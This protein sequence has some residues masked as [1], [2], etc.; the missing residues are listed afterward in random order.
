MGAGRSALLAIS[1][2]HGDVLV[3]VGFLL[4]L[5]AGVRLVAA[6]VI[7]PVRRWRVFRRVVAGALL[8]VAGGLL[9]IAAYT[10]QLS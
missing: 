10:G 8:A 5:I 2:S 7:P 4:I 3:E 1:V 6:E 9:I